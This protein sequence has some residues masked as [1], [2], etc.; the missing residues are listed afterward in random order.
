MPDA[1]GLRAQWARFE[2]VQ[3]AEP[4]GI[5]DALGRDLIGKEVPKSLW[6]L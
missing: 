6:G 5:P 3:F 2:T 4:T 1:A